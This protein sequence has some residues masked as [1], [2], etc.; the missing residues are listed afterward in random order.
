MKYLVI[1]NFASITNKLCGQSVKTRNIFNLAKEIV[2]TIDCFDTQKI[3]YNKFSIFLMLWKFCRSN[4][5][6][7]LPAAG[8]M[9]WLFPI[10][11]ILSIVSRTY[12]LQFEIGNWMVDLLANKPIHRWMLKGIKQFYAET[13]KSKKELKHLYGLENISVFSN[14]RY[15][16]FERENCICDNSILKLVFCARINRKKGLD[17]IFSLGDYLIEEKKEKSVSIT[18][19]GPIFEKDEEYFWRNLNKYSFMKYD[20]MLQQDEI[21]EKLQYFDCMLLPT[22]Y[23]TEGLPGSIIDA[24]IVGIPVIV[25][26]WKNAEEFVVNNITGIIIPFQ[27]GQNEFNQAVVD[28]MNNKEKLQ[29]L[30]DNAY[31]YRYKFHSSSAKLHL[32]RI[33]KQA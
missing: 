22:Q 18:F 4:Y 1:G 8:N 11:Y 9:T 12:I 29:Y 15:F 6:I 14:F 33:L 24:Y 17:M 21:S 19:Y 28:L 26:K 30:K 5:V 7:Y 2:P 16:D 31:H 23:Y 13:E 27:D 25:T 20:G 3:K 10:F 32:K